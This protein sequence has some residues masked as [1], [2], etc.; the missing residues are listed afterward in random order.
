[1]KCDIGSRSL[2]LTKTAAYRPMNDLNGSS[3]AWRWLAK[4]TDVVW[5]GQMIA[6]CAPKCW[7]KAMN[8]S[9]D[10]GGKCLYH[11]NVDTLREVGK[12]LH[13]IALSLEYKFT[14]VVSASRCSFGFDVPLY[15][16]MCNG[17]QVMGKGVSTIP[18]I[19]GWK[20][21]ASLWM[22]L[23]LWIA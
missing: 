21:I 13:N 19:K 23:S 2:I 12:T 4:A 5:W 22:S 7:P 17:F 8:E 15:L 3:L 11:V 9:M 20:W 14:W 18:S 10:R 6:Y 16:S 1:M